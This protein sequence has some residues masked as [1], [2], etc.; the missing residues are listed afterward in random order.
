[1]LIQMKLKFFLGVLTIFVFFSLAP[2][3]SGASNLSYGDWELD[4]FIRN[5]TGIWTESWDYVHSN[6]S[7]ATFRNW[8]R[9]NLNGKLSGSMRL[10]AEALAVWEPEYER[11]KGGNIPA[12]YYNNF[13]FR[14][15]R[16]DWRPANSHTIR[17]GRQIVN[18]GE[19]ISA[20]VGDVVNP[21]DGRFD[22][23][24][25][26]LED[27]RIP[28]WMVRG[29]H[30]M[31]SLRSSIDWIFSPYMEP[32]RYRVSRTLGWGAGM[33]LAD[34]TWL[35]TAEQKFTASPDYRFFGADGKQ[36]GASQ[37]LTINPATGAFVPAPV[38]WAPLN[39]IYTKL[40]ASVDLGPGLGLP[41][42]LVIT[43][44]E[45]YYLLS[46]PNIYRIDYP[47]SN[48]SDARYGFKTSS[49]INGWETGAYFWRAHIH[50]PPVIYKTP[51][52]N[53]FKIVYERQNTFGFYANKNYSFGVV[54][55]DA[56]YR[57]DCDYQ[58]VDETEHTDLVTEIDT[59]QVQLGY[60]KDFMIHSVNPN[61]AFGLIAEYVGEFLLTGDTDDALA[62]P[63]W[64]VRKPRDTH[65]LM[66]SLGTNYNFGMYSYN[67]TVI[68]NMKN[69]GL[70]Q[71][72]ISYAPAWMDNKWT[73]KVQYNNVFADNDLDYLYGFFR[74]KDMLVLTT[75]FSF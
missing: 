67:L 45:G 22:L 60:N 74:E 47:D 38:L 29:L 14:E 61:Q 28:I 54:R 10:K 43:P 56:A 27:T 2:C 25:T 24:F 65:T 20:R 5:N 18:W 42:G 46:Y 16:I 1:M 75:Q 4:G 48:L 50:S 21:V 33:F 31:P 30:M 9:L 12:N 40:P 58:T 63:L 41:P 52:T 26:N 36:Y 49:I 37:V 69:N 68:Y 73:F 13:D 44:T 55:M 70:I 59:L 6:D 3:R 72:S 11:E 71:P 39:T 23:G 57:P 51:G 62:S 35:G 66:F 15:L 7:L 8:F 53:D 17:I 34:G 64:Y 19:S 32:D